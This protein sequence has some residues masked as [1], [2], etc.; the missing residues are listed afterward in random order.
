MRDFIDP[1]RALADPSRARILLALRGR[2]LCVCQLV[3]LL[4]LAPSTV[5]KHMTVLRQAHLVASRKDGRWIYY[6]RSGRQASAVARAGLRWL[7]MAL[8]DSDVA[9]RD[10]KRLQLILRV[11]LGDICRTSAGD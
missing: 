8:A 2:E 7:D 9:G 5:S 1:A 11:P 10:A 3:E 4:G 6:R